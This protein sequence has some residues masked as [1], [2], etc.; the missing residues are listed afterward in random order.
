[1]LF[2]LQFINSSNDNVWLSRI[3]TS[4]LST[5]YAKV[6]HRNVLKKAWNSI[7]DDVYLKKLQTKGVKKS[8]L[9]VYNVDQPI[10][11]KC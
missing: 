10:R 8:I 7:D 9:Y 4:G 6:K 11:H 5:L 1:M 2:V 3:T